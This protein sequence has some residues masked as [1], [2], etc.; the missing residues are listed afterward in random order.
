MGILSAEWKKFITFRE[1]YAALVLS[2]VMAL[3]GIL[4]LQGDFW[5]NVYNFNAGVVPVLILFLQAA[6]LSRLFCWE[7]SGRTDPLLRVGR[8]G[9]RDTFGAKL[10]LGLGYGAAASLF[11]ILLGFCLHALRCG[12]IPASSGAGA[13][14]R[15]P[16]WET[17]GPLAL[18]GWQLLFSLLGGLCAAGLVLLCS[19]LARRPASA[20][21][22]AGLCLALPAALRIGVVALFSRFPLPQ[23]LIAILEGLYRLSGYTWPSILSYDAQLLGEN[24]ALLWQPILYCLCL[25]A[26]ELALTWAAWTRRAR[27]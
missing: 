18:W 8:F 5:T 21:L 27:T 1:V 4:P 22:G 3:W 20:M 10:A 24:G 7:R 19:A 12:G 15:I 26:A 23:A 11:P 16:L 14:S 25:L 17:A 2:I 13:V 9:L 6:G